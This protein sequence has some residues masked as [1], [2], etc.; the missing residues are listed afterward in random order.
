MKI[1][2]RSLFKA[3]AAGV[4]SAVALSAAVPFVSDSGEVTIDVDG[5]TVYSQ[6]GGK[7]VI[8][9]TPRA[10]ISISSLM[11]GERRTYIWNHEEGGWMLEVRK[12][13]YMITQVYGAQSTWRK[14]PGMVG[15]IELLKGPGG[16]IKDGDKIIYEDWDGGKTTLFYYKDL[17]G[18]SP[19]NI[20]IIDKRNEKK[21][22][23]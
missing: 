15:C 16:N 19:K 1:S 21:R 20:V 22:L 5:V 7:N 10:P 17:D 18:N 13:P 2:R 11:P 12:M 8:I 3:V 14:T 6:N 4:A 23:F 9:N